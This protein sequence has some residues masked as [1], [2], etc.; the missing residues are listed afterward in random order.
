MKLFNKIPLW[1]CR[2]CAH[3]HGYCP[4]ADLSACSFV[5]RKKKRIYIAKIYTIKAP[6][7]QPLQGV[8][9]MVVNERLNSR[10]VC[11]TYSDALRYYFWHLG[12][13]AKIVF[14]KYLRKKK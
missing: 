11:L 10:D 13:P 14:R 2:R 9:W 1:K 5:K 8:K 4:L 7:D 6:E 3:Y 12:V